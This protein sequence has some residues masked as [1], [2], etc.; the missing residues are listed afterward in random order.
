M[1]NSSEK[2]F[3]GI[4]QVAV[5]CCKVAGG[6]IEKTIK[7]KLSIPVEYKR[8]KRGGKNAIRSKPGEPPRRQTGKLQAGVEYK[9]QQQGDQITLTIQD[10]VPY[11]PPLQNS[12]NRPIIVNASSYADTI[13]DII[14]TELATR[15]DTI[16]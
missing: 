12:M 9:V 6:E 14:E 11:A 1:A 8:G 2:L 13:I 3:D 5:E 15:L 10:L 4:V 16:N 7:E